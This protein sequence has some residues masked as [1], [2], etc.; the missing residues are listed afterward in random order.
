M[1]KREQ[2]I[3]R[4]SFPQA[5]NYLQNGFFPQAKDAG[6]GAWI[7]LLSPK[8][9]VNEPRLFSMLK[10]LEKNMFLTIQIEE[11]PKSESGCN[12]SSQYKIAEHVKIAIL[13]LIPTCGISFIVVPLVVWVKSNR[14]KSNFSKTS[15]IL[16]SEL[17]T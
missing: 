12:L 9:I 6:I 15:L 10:V 14:W 7:Q 16:K 5:C 11:T 13:A 2:F 4:T 3:V 1:E 17:G 8:I